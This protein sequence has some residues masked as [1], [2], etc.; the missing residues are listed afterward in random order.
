LINKKY[1]VKCKKCPSEFLI[2]ERDQHKQEGCRKECS[3]KCGKFFLKKEEI[4]KHLKEECLNTKIKCVACEFGG[5]RGE[6]LVHQE[7]CEKAISLL[8]LFNPFNLKIQ[9]E[10]EKIEQ[11]NQKI[12]L[13]LSENEQQNQKMEQQNRKIQQEEEKIEQ[14]N[15]KIILLLSENEQQNRKLQQQEEKIEQQNHKIIFLLSEN[16]DLKNILNVLFLF[17]FCFLFLSLDRSEKKKSEFSKK[18]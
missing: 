4:K 6:V 15:Q 11:Q 10:E 5:R 17:L 16:Q 3:Q 18:L 9:Q 13:L 12:I 14:Q 1:K 8:E 2:G 7:I